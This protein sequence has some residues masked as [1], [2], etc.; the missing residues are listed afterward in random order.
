MGLAFLNT[1]IIPLL[2]TSQAL[3]INLISECAVISSPDELAG[4]LINLFVVKKNK[5]IYNLNELINN[6][7]KKNFGV[8]AIP[9]NIYY[10]DQLPKTKSG[11]ILRR[12]LRDII[13]DKV[14]GDLSTINNKKLIKKIKMNIKNS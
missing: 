4:N 13:D 8:Y 9:K 7:I 2:E 12:L 11:K 1:S 5:N 10:L 3:E 6:S 14:S